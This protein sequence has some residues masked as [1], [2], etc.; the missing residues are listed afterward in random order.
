MAGIV[1]GCEAISPIS[2]GGDS[3]IRI[4]NNVLDSSV[5]FPDFE[6]ITES[7]SESVSVVVT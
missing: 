4:T 3:V 6:G 2:A 5:T 1:G 7:V